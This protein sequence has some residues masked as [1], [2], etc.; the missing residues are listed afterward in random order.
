[1]RHIKYILQLLVF[2]GFN[3][4]YAGAYE[5]F[6]MAAANNDAPAVERLLRLGFDANT[7]GPQGQSA[8]LTAIRQ[9]AHQA[10]LVLAKWPETR[11]DDRTTD[12]E[13]PLM[14]A[15]FHN[16]MPL[17]Q[18]LLDRRADVNKTGWTPL[19]YAA[20]KAHVDMMRFLLANHAY[21]DAPSPNG[22][23]PLMMAAHYGN[24]M[25]TKMLLEEGADPRLKNHLG[26]SALDFAQNGVHA[27]ESSTYINAFLSS[28][29]ARFPS[30]P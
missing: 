10:A 13:T 30:K 27:K 1:M 24:P 19:H 28:W 21:I 14:L 5:D 4:A 8:L 23:T 15:A 25:A 9:N 2:I 29:H 17:A 16:A 7:P 6:F 12:D 3:S 18:A 26:L 22:T 20:T 11:V